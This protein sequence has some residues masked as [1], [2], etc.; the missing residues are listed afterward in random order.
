MSASRH[1]SAM[2]ACPDIAM[3]SGKGQQSPARRAPQLTSALKAEVPRSIHPDF[4]GL[5]GFVSDIKSFVPNSRP[6]RRERHG[7]SE[8]HAASAARALISP[9]MVS[10]KRIC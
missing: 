9:L 3:Y 7:N 5:I 1:I 4:I 8:R 10:Y 6:P 2:G